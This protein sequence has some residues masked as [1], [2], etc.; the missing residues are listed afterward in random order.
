MAAGGAAQFAMALRKKEI[1]VADGRPVAVS[2]PD[3]LYFPTAGITKL[4]LVRYYLVVADGAL[5][6]VRD[7]PM[8]L[9][10]HVEGAEGAFFFQKRAGV[11]A[12]AGSTWWSSASRR[13]GARTRSSSAAR[14]S[15]PG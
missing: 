12:C 1:L 3:K 4:D 7:R 6:G 11:A 14:R 8:A 15:S 2:N 10:R 9:K 5:R 13:G